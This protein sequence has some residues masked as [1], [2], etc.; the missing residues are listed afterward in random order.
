MQRLEFSG[1][2]R[3]QSV[4]RRQRVNLLGT[5]NHVSHYTVR[6]DIKEQTP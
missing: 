3:P 5:K 2:V 6:R 4:V 1:A